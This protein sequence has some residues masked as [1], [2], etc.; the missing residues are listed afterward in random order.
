MQGACLGQ[1]RR[2]LVLMFMNVDPHEFLVRAF[3]LDVVIT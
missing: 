1:E 2:K 3:L